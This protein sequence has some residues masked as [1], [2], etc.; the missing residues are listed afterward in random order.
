MENEQNKMQLAN[1]HYN[2]GVIA[3]QSGLYEIAIKEYEKALEYNPESH[4]KVVI[5]VNCANTIWIKNNFQN[6]DGTTISDKEYKDVK[7]TFK[8]YDEAVKLYMGLTEL[9]DKNFARESYEKAKTNLQISVLY[10][11][12]KR[13]KNGKP[14]F[15]EDKQLSI[16]EEESDDDGVNTKDIHESKK[17]H[18]EQIYDDFN[19]LNKVLNWFRISDLRLRIPVYYGVN[20]A[21]LF[22]LSFLGFIL[23][24]T[25]SIEVFF[26]V[27]F[28]GLFCGIFTGLLGYSLVMGTEVVNKVLDV[29]HKIPY[30]GIIT[31]FLIRMPYYIHGWTAEKIYSHFFDK[32][33][34]LAEGANLVIEE[35]YEEAAK[36]LELA[37]VRDKDLEGNFILHSSLGKTYLE[38]QR[39]PE[40]I[41]ECKIALSL[42]SE[43][44]KTQLKLAEAYAFN[45]QHNESLEMLREIL[46]QNPEESK[47]IGLMGMVYLMEEMYDEAIQHLK[48]GISLYPQAADCH[49]MLAEAYVGKNMIEE[50]TNEAQKAL[51][52][53]PP[54]DIAEAAKRIINEHGEN[55]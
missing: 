50:A 33:T 39:Y 22:L 53:N 1:E 32:Y 21:I 10:G 49:V 43:D 48:K 7:K 12:T 55:R 30:S 3:G 16:S 9:D 29:V 17:K 14:I 13:D 15:R 11:L 28:G 20:S 52:L 6:R 54:D 18:E 42:E 45:K 26:G 36:K 40:T 46:K 23:E 47:A 35:R 37:I 41:N 25:E 34:F 4:F 5:N 51:S 44:V 24:G 2:K 8:L 31:L 19:F 27:L 38:L